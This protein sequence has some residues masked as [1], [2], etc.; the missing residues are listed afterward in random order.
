MESSRLQRRDKSLLAKRSVADSADRRER[1]ATVSCPGSA[2]TVHGGNLNRCAPITRVVGPLLAA[3]GLR[4]SYG[5]TFRV[6]QR[7]RRLA[8][9]SESAESRLVRELDD[10]RNP[11]RSKESPVPGCSCLSVRALSVRQSRRLSDLGCRS[12]RGRD[13]TCLRNLPSKCTR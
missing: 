4:R 3:A 8:V 10:R 6:R 5:S 7:E 2:P 1:R 9:Q 13:A 11:A 12:L